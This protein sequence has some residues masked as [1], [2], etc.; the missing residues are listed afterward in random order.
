MFPMFPAFP[1]FRHR[2]PEE[3]RAARRH[4]I[5][6]DMARMSRDLNALYRSN[7]DVLSFWEATDIAHAAS[8][9]LSATAMMERNN[10]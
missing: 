2:T 1:I 9:A 4:R 10:R 6:A 3:R 8:T 7:T 5:W